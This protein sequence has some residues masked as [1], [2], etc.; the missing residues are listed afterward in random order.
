MPNLIDVNGLIPVVTFRDWIECCTTPIGDEL[1]ANRLF[2]LSNF[3]ESGDAHNVDKNMIYQ[4][5]SLVSEDV[6]WQARIATAQ[7]LAILANMLPLEVCITFSRGPSLKILQAQ[8]EYFDL[9]LRHYLKS[10]SYFHRFMGATIL[11]EW[12]D[13][14]QHTSG[15]P[16]SSHLK[17][18]EDLGNIV[19]EFI[20][21]DPPTCYHETFSLLHQCCNVANVHADIFM[22]DP[23]LNAPAAGIPRA[24]SLLDPGFFTIDSAKA[25]IEWFDGLHNLFQKPKKKK[26]TA[27]VEDAKKA[28]REL[29]YTFEERKSLQDLRVYAALAAA[30]VSLKNMPSKL[31]PLIKGVTNSLKVSESY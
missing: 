8:Q 7:C 30:A 22:N 27:R 2:I 17:L 20:A 13:E 28:V 3:T 23:K 1:D 11:Q 21:T 9:P 31:T 5:L 6:V 10:P 25:S 26:D 14:F 29:M 15:R 4:D 19:L 16:L 18:A 24:V 12:A